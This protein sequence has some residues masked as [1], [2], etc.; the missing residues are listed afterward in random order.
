M[1]AEKLDRKTSQLLVL[2]LHNDF[3]L[4]RYLLFVSVGTISN[5]DIAVKNS[6]T[7]FLINSNPN[8]TSTAL[9]FPRAAEPSVRRST[10]VGAAGS[11]KAKTNSSANANF[12]P[13]TNAQEA[14]PITAQ[15]LTSR[16]SKLAKIF[17]GERATCRYITAGIHSQYFFLYDKIRQLEAGNSDAIIWKFPLLKFLIDS[18]KVSQPSSDPLTAPATG[19][20]SSIFR[21]LPRGY[22]FVFKFY[23][24]GFGP[25]S[26]KCASILFTLFPG[27]YDNLLQWPFSKLIH[28]GIRDQLD[29]LNTWTKTIQPDEDPAYKKPTIS[30]KTGAATIIINNFIAHSKLFIETEGF[31]I[32]GA[33]FIVIKFNDTSV[34]KSQAQTSLLSPFPQSFSL[35]FQRCELSCYT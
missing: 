2:Q 17:A 33:S 28:I 18:A 7:S 16:I 14:P 20:S 12:Q 27:D 25:A 10:P 1:E 15:N 29:P 13:T 4:L 11:P 6:A 8:S 3:A 19:F 23:P 34:L 9:L 35:L 21:T 30:T 26:G 5:K 22:N 32:D 31:L 24:Y